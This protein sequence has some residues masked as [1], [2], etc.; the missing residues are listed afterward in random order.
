MIL[1]MRASFNLPVSLKSTR[2]EKGF[3]LLE[4]LLVVAATAILAGIVILA[5]NPAKQ[6]SDTKNAQRKIDVNTILNAVYQYS[7]DHSGALPTT[8]TT[9]P[10]EICK[11]TATS[12]TNLIDLS[13]L[14]SSERYLIG[15]PNDPSGGTLANGTGYKIAKDQYGRLVVS[16]PKA[17][18]GATISIT[19]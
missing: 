13:A 5:I 3:T 19:R 11:T 2:S 16:A 17:E 18:V 7:I 12:C 8:I 6:L 9:T 10:T 14:T 4:I 15:M 1:Y